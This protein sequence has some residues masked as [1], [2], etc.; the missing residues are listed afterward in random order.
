MDFSFM[1]N[2]FL[3]IIDQSIGCLI[4]SRKSVHDSV[5]N[6]SSRPTIFNSEEKRDN[7]R[8]TLATVIKFL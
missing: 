6:L 5:I 4:I 2:T 1:F 8:A 7:P 3:S